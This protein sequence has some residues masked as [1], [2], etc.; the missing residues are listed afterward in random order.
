MEL[1][2]KLKDSDVIMLGPCPSGIS[3]IKEQYRWQIVLKG[4]I[5]AVISKG[6]FIVNE[7]KF[8]GGQGKY[9]SRRLQI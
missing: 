3:K 9:L 4:E 8:W 7:G 1:K 5:S 6:K 2:N